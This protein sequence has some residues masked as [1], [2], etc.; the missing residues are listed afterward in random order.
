[1]LAHI[2]SHF[3]EIFGSIF[4][5]ARQ[6]E[7]PKDW[8]SIIWCHGWDVSWSKFN[9]GIPRKKWWIIFDW[10]VSLTEIERRL[11]QSKGS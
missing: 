9:V 10:L 3:F 1:M 8:K 4:K 11:E 5:R 7:A 6:T 2:S